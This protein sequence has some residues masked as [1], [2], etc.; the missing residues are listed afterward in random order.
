MSEVPSVS[1]QMRILE[2]GTL[3]ER[4]VDRTR[5]ALECGALLSIPTDYEFVEQDG[6]QFLVRILSN[7][8]RKEKANKQQQ[9]K[10]TDSGKEFNPFLPYEEDLFVANLSDTHLCLLNKFN[11]VDHHLLIITRD[12]EEQES[13]LTLQDFLALWICLAEYEGL[14]FYN[15]GKNAGASQRHKHLQLVPFPLAPQA[16]KLPIEPLLAT[17]QDHGTIATLPEFPFLH[18]LI[19][20]DSHCTKPPQQAAEATIAL[21]HTLLRAVGLEKGGAY[22]LLATRDWMLIVPRL[23]ES[24]QSISINSLGFAG[25]LFVRSEDQLQRLKEIR[26]LTILTQVSFPKN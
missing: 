5:H 2:P 8:V 21:Y 26:P 23:Q 19:R 16:A 11:V 24:Y 7:L 14:A 25:S 3:W 6:V 9:Q 17:V 22:N 10:T 4:V 20:F 13:L 12:F 1:E 15:A 18:A